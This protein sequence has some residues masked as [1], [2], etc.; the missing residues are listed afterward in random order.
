MLT[1]ASIFFNVVTILILYN[2]K[3]AL[4]KPAIQ[5]QLAFI[6]RSMLWSLL[7]YVAAMLVFNWD[8][9][10]NVVKGV[11]AVTVV[12]DTIPTSQPCTCPERLPV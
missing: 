4:M 1:L 5:T 11:K 8:D 2:Q 10:R 12:T 3:C 9:V 6:G 7:L